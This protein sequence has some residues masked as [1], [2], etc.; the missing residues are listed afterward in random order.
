[1]AGWCTSFF[2]WSGSS[3]YSTM[4]VCV[5]CTVKCNFGCLRRYDFHWYYYAHIQQFRLLIKPLLRSAFW[6]LRS[7]RLHGPYF[8]I[9]WWTKWGA[10]PC[11][12]LTSRSPNSWRRT[13][14]IQTLNLERDCTQVRQTS[15]HVPPALLVALHMMH[16]EIP[17][18]ETCSWDP[19]AKWHLQSAVA[20]L[21]FI[22]LADDIHKLL[23]LHQ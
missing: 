3:A 7:T 16:F 15:S 14:S 21:D 13:P 10:Q 8:W 1:M 12:N 22:F 9:K 20:L 6:F 23:A 18:Q 2:A 17:G 4:S 5:L 11:Q 19:H